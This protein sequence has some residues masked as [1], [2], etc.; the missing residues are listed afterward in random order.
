MKT[1]RDDVTG[2]TPEALIATALGG[3]NGV[4][5][6]STKATSPP[7]CSGTDSPRTGA[8]LSRIGRFRS[9]TTPTAGLGCCAEGSRILSL[10]SIDG[11]RRLSPGDGISV[12]R[13]FVAR[14]K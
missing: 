9:T 4:D 5:E 12:R 2:T 1:N 14:R 6:T 7:N 13:I 8:R 10:A 3:L 11:A